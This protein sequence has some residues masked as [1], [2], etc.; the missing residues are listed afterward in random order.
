MIS[1][2]ELGLAERNSI[3]LFIHLFHVLE[4]AFKFKRNF[5]SLGFCIHFL[6]REKK[7]KALC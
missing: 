4:T 1:L 5:F 6:Q 3:S 7:E 2:I